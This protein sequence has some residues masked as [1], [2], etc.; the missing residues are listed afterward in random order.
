M[1]NSTPMTMHTG[2]WLVLICI[3]LTVLTACGTVPAPATAQTA[4]AP[5]LPHIGYL[6]MC[7]RDKDEAL[8]ECT[9]RPG[10]SKEPM[11]SELWEAL[12]SVTWFVNR[13]VEPMDDS[14][15]YQQ[16]DYWTYPESGSG[17]CEDYA[18]EKKR[19]LINRGYS[20]NALDLAVVLEQECY[21]DLSLCSAHAVLI[22]ATDRGEF[23]LD[24]LNDAVKP[25][26]QTDYIYL[27]RQQQ[28]LTW[29]RVPGAGEKYRH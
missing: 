21:E 17:D 16:A 11:G 25:I 26:E 29:V 27:K 20:P 3:G 9:E 28:D 13:S 5:T 4:G 22:V 19:Q 18:L 24:N 14:V 6:L 10:R 2:Y 1:T 12:N 7:M 15:Q 23:V 8:P